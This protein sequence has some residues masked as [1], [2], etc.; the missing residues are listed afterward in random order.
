VTGITYL[1][2]NNEWSEYAAFVQ[3][4]VQEHSARKICDVGGGANPVLPLQFITENQLDCT[5]LD[6]S[7][8]E[9]DKA[10]CGYKKLVQDIE[11]ERCGP[12]D[13][14]DLVITKMMAEHL[15]NGR[16]FHK[17]IFSMLKPG[18][19]AV[20]YFP[21]LYALPFLV[22][23]WVPERLS[24]FLLDIFLPR[25]RYQRAK[26]PAY[27]SWC[28]GPTPG[29]LKMLTE[30]GYEIVQYNGFFGNIY[31]TRVPI[32]RDLHRVYTRYLV[33]HPN[34]YLTSFAQVVLRKPEIPLV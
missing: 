23:K 25:D 34:P 10:P 20:H 6:I 13:L 32:L 33:K 15:R 12:T 21:T 19:V 2:S 27:Y 14:F 9:L 4:L 18:G 22:N 5:I 29:M 8:A 28:Y 24:S 26:F 3:N 30:I 7:S 17:N 11:A 31:Y 16:L 1:H